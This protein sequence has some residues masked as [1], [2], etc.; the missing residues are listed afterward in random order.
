MKNKDECMTLEE[1]YKEGFIVHVFA[2]KYGGCLIPKPGETFEQL[3]LRAAN[4]SSN[5][6]VWLTPHWC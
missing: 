2:G 3:I 5:G 1:L 6:D 4:E